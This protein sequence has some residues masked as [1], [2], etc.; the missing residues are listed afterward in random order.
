MAKRQRRTA[1]LF[2]SP[3]IVYF[4]LFFFWPIVEE[5]RLS[6]TRG[7][8]KLRPVGVQNYVDILHDPAVR[9]SFLITLV[10][11]AVVL[12]LSTIVGLLL[13][14]ILNQNF[15]GRTVARTMILTPYMTSIAIVGL[16]WRNILDPTTGVLNTVLT[17]LG[18]PGQHWL[19]TAPLA[20]LIGITVWQEAGYIML[21]FL[22]GLQGL[23]QQVYEAARIDGASVWR[24]FWTITLP[25]LAPTTL[26]VVLVGMIGTLQQFGLPYLVTGGGPGDATSLY[27]YQVYRETF[28]SGELGYASAMSFCFL[29]VILALSL[30][31]IRAG[32]K[33]EA[34]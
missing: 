21:L 24:R 33:K 6:F 27:V 22:A 20:T 7:F 2:L 23:D 28:S 10:Y 29:V 5:F 4:G 1:Y 3:A 8:R 9:H 16:M 32:K 18:L 30:L 14:L 25:L 15:R 19:T 31:Q 13:A 26:F 12:L 11:A 34:L 17:G